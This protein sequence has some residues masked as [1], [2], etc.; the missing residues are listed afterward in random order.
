MSY[1]DQYVAVASTGVY[2]AG[3]ACFKAAAGQM[4]ELRGA[5][6]VHLPFALTTHGLRVTGAVVLM[7]GAL[8]QGGH[9]S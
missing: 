4:P 8:L 1:A 3:L 9:R 5:R 7:S 6:P 2:F